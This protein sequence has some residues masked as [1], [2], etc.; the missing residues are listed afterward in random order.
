MHWTLVGMRGF[1]CAWSS[2]S[3]C[4]ALVIGGASRKPGWSS[5]TLRVV[6]RKEKF[7][8]STV[9]SHCVCVSN[10]AAAGQ[11]AT[12][13]WENATSGLRAFETA[14][15]LAVND[16]FV[17]GKQFP[18]LF[19]FCSLYKLLVYTWAH[20]PHYLITLGSADWFKEMSWP[21]VTPFF[22]ALEC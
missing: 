7:R 22:I 4:A 8:E 12:W 1:G 18:R 6:L 17:I 3:P 9:P 15:S 20:T 19:L 2:T 16:S 11:A 5:H 13:E 21:K 10:Q 14:L